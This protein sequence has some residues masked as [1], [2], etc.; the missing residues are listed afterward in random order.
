MEPQN[1][2]NAEA[3]LPGEKVMEEI[4]THIG[5]NFLGKNKHFQQSFCK[6]DE[7]GVSS[8]F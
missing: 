6:T 3:A 4:A 5:R 7:T 8:A 1:I 2:K